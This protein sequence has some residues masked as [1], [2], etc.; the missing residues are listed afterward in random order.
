MKTIADLRESNQLLWHDWFYFTRGTCNIRHNEQLYID[1]IVVFK[2]KFGIHI[3]TE[4]NTLL[5]NSEAERKAI[6]AKIVYANSCNGSHNK[7]NKQPHTGVSAITESRTHN[8]F[9][10]T[11]ISFIDIIF[12]KTS[13]LSSRISFHQKNISNILQ[14][15]G[16][17][18][19]RTH[20]KDS[21]R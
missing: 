10:S 13:M 19:K 5:S 11:Y 12:I 16:I 7:S 20:I 3:D 18:Q 6:R 9:L 14:K 1:S 15:T 17:E 2:T 4:T 21:M 8:L